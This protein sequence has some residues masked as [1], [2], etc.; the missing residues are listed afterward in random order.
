MHNPMNE[1]LTDLLPEDRRI[2]LRR[3]YYLRLSTVALVLATILVGIAGVLLTPT[4]VYLSAS[5]HA[6]Q[7]RLAN[8]RAALASADE[9]ALSNRLAT[10][11]SDAAIL[12]ALSNAPSATA[13]FQEL[14]AIARPGVTITALEYAQASGGQPAKLD[15]S[16]IAATRDALRSY[17]V[18]L[19]AAPFVSSADLPVSVFAK[20]TDI[21]FTISVTLTP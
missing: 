7:I 10:L 16:G 11:S 18:A 14:L 21:S 4:Y 13:Y 6:K 2:A 5:A 19:Q 12:T 3:E 17:Q 8:V 1:P 9:S 15:V 20:D